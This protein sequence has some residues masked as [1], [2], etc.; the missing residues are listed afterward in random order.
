MKRHIEQ[1]FANSLRNESIAVSYHYFESNNRC[2]TVSHDAFFSLA[3][4]HD[5]EELLLVSNLALWH[6]R[7]CSNSFKINRA[8]SSKISAIIATAIGSLS[9]SP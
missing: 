5:A 8:I 6:D 2:S 3:F 7:S 9:L 4:L 1:N